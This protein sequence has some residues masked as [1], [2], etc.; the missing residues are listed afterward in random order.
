MAR[1]RTLSPDEV[2]GLRAELSGGGTPTVWFTASAVGVDEGRSGKVIAM[3]EPAEGDFIQVRP[4]GSKD[5]LAFSAAE[6]TVTKPPR[7][8]KAPEPASPSTTPPAAP[9]WTPA[10][11][12]AT[13]SNGARSNGTAKSVAGTTAAATSSASNGSASTAARGASGRGGAKRAPRQVGGA[14]VTLTASAEGQWSVEVHNGKKR[15]LK[16]TTVPASAVAQAAKAL[17]DEVAEAVDPLIEAARDQQRERVE[18]LQ[19]ELEA[20]Q[21]MLDELSG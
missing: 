8:R 9:T 21:A 5:V 2:Q 17:T 4:A 3:D 20:A 7:K 14:T 18:Q 19:A 16:P 15:V 1:T 6:V 13:Q 12:P 10:P 11:A